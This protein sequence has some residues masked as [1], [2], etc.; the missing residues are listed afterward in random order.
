MYVVYITRSIFLG[1]SGVY[2]GLSSLG[3]LFFAKQKSKGSWESGEPGLRGQGPLGK[4]S[5][6]HSESLLNTLE[7]YFG[8][9]FK[10]KND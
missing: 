9:S 4:V 5:C 8:D 10:P 7:C 3:I 2:P 1:S 6:L